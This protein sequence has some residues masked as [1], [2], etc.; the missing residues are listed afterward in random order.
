MND[1]WSLFILGPV[2]SFFIITAHA[3]ILAEKLSKTNGA[4]EHTSIAYGWCAWN[5]NWPIGIEQ[6]GKNLT[7]L[8][9]MKVSTEIRHFFSLKKALN[10]HEKGF[11]IPK[12]ISAWKKR[13]VWNILC[14]LPIWRQKWVTSASLVVACV[15]WTKYVVPCQIKPGI[16]KLTIRKG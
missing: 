11:A 13:K 9:S 1:A 15:N 14:L 10:I 5:L 8:T 4:H 6:A 3:E 7:V 12:T 2:P 16:L